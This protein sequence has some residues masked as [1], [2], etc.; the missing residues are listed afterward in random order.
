M[1]LSGVI[2][3]LAR[4]VKILQHQISGIHR[5]STLVARERSESGESKFLF[6]G[7]I[8]SPR[9]CVRGKGWNFGERMMLKNAVCVVVW[10]AVHLSTRKLKY[11]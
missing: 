2:K 8:L 6:M 4:L 3:R 5:D 11:L 10:C 9:E 1:A 7:L